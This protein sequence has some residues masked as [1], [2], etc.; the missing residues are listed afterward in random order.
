MESP[1]Q[2]PTENPRIQGTST[3]IID[4]TLVGKRHYLMLKNFKNAKED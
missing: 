2:K 1:F 4:I 3:G